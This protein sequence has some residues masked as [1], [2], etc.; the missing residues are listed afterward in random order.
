MPGRS[1]IGRIDVGRFFEERARSLV[2]LQQ[3]LGFAEK[4][5]VVAAVCGQ[6]RASHGCGLI[7]RSLKDVFQTIP[8][9]G[10]HSASPPSPCP[11]PP[12][13]DRLSHARASA[14]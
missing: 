12:S 13:S 10:R 5:R 3:R 1:E 6:P 11:L 9:F 14:H 8:L 2:G 7:E 4:R